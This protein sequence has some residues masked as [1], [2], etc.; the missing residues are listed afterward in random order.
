[1]RIVV[2]DVSNAAIKTSPPYTVIC[3]A[4]TLRHLR[5]S[6]YGQLTVFQGSRGRAVRVLGYN[7][8]KIMQVLMVIHQVRPFLTATQSSVIALRGARF[9][10]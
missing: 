2:R 1:M 9:R 4:A 8:G 7:K 3:R 6:L 10:G 5:M